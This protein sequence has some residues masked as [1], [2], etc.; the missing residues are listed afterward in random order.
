M[1]ENKFNQLPGYEN[2]FKNLKNVLNQYIKISGSKRIHNFNLNQRNLHDSGFE[3]NL[4]ENDFN[5]S[6]L[7]EEIKN[8]YLSRDYLEGEIG[9]IDGQDQYDGIFNIALYT[10]ITNRVGKLYQHQ[11]NKNTNLDANTRTA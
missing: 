1:N 7:I 5:P 11:L 9:L 8:S 3:N 2:I 6:E 10:L 4:I